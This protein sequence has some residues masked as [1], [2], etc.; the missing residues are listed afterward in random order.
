MKEGRGRGLG[1]GVSPGARMSGRFFWQQDAHVR[2]L[3]KLAVPRFLSL[4]GIN[5][6]QG[7]RLT[8]SQAGVGHVAMQK[9]PFGADPCKSAFVCVLISSPAGST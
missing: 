6:H 9:E 7:V 5:T 2:R 1:R 3:D 8:H 4:Q